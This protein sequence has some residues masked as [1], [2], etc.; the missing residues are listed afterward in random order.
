MARKPG[1][2]KN[3]TQVP[4]ALVDYWMARVSSP[5]YKILSA[6]ARKTIGWQKSE[7]AISIKQLKN[8]TGLSHAT[9]IKDI[10]CLVA[11]DLIF[12]RKEKSTE[13]DDAPSVYSINFVV[14][15]QCGG[16][17]KEKPRSQESLEGS[18]T[19]LPPVDSEFEYGAQNDLSR[20]VEMPTNPGGQN[21]LPTKESFPPKE[22][23]TEEIFPK[24]TAIKEPHSSSSSSSLGV[25]WKKM[26]T[27]EGWPDEEVEEALRR[28]AVQ[29][30]GSIV[31]PR[32]WLETTLQSVRDSNWQKAEATKLQE[33]RKQEVERE[34]RERVEYH[35][36]QRQA[37]ERK[38][39]ERQRELEEAETERMWQIKR[40]EA[41]AGRF[42]GRSWLEYVPGKTYVKLIVNGESYAGCLSFSEPDFCRI[43]LECM[44]KEASSEELAV[45]RLLLELM[46]KQSDEKG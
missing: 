30:F 9:V 26:K 37:E 2:Q 12:Q 46:K 36:Q 7:D 5:Q 41:L 40:N 11:R 6:I 27:S 24:S 1:I 16:T 3:Y 17:K 18:L 23:F 44:E 28:Y 19:D 31:C 10:K 43:F 32:A 15:E 29:P 4:N 42:Q 35:D 8:I 22:T 21:P 20:V 13:G 14:L 39:Q 45:A 38:T 33:T 34:T 25:D